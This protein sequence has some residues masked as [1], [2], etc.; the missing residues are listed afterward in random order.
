MQYS[1]N[2]QTTS[3][4]LNRADQRAPVQGIRNTRANHQSMRFR[5]TTRFSKSLNPFLTSKSL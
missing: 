5:R 4:T 3:R 2:R 1:A